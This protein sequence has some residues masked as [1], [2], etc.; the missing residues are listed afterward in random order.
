M[1]YKPEV[2]FVQRTVAEDYGVPGAYSAAGSANLLGSQYSYIIIF[3]SQGTGDTQ[4]IGDTIHPIKLWVRIFITNVPTYAQLVARIIIFTMN[5]DC[6][7]VPT[8][9]NFWQG[10]TRH[11]SIMGT[12]NLEVVRKVYFDKQYIISSQY[13]AIATYRKTTHVNIRLKKPVVFAGG[14]TSPKNPAD[15]FYIAYIV[16]DVYN[17]VTATCASVNVFANYYW[18]DN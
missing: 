6:T 4:R 11:P 7:A 2:K 15:N 16:E 8:I 3:P 1:R 17:N 10:S 18:V 5:T 14:S 9:N 13:A 12:V